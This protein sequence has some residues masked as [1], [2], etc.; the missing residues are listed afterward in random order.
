MDREYQKI[1]YVRSQ[2]LYQCF[3]DQKNKTPDVFLITG[4]DAIVL[5][6]M[7]K[8]IGIAKANSREKYNTT[9]TQEVK[10]TTYNFFD[11]RLV[12]A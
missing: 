6:K 1:P 8:E 7:A 10:K 11:K 12:D 9:N 5:D 2:Y 3:N 4:N